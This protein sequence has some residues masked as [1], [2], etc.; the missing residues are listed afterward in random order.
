MDQ[1]TLP[2]TGELER[3]PEPYNPDE[4][5]RFIIARVTSRLGEGPRAASRLALERVW[6]RNILF[7]LGVQWLDWDSRARSYTPIKAPKWF[8]QPV[9]NEIYPRV[10]RLVAQFLKT[11]PVARVRPNTGEP[12]DREAAKTAEQLLGHIEDVV[13]EDQLRHRLALGLTLCGT[14]IS[15]E[16]FN[17]QTGPIVEVPETTTRMDPVMD[18]V[19]GCETPG[20]MQ[21]MGPEMEGQDCPSC[22]GPLAMQRFQR[23]SPSGSLEYQPVQDPVLDPETGEP[24]VHRFYQG[25]IQSEV[26]YPFAFFKDPNADTLE[27]AEW[28][29]DISYRPLEWIRRNF[30]DN[31]RFVAEESGVGVASF[32][33]SALLQVV[34]QSDPGSSSP[35]RMLTG[36]A[37]VLCYE[38]RPSADFPDGLAAIVAHG[39]LLWY[40]PLPIS[41]EFS[42][43]ACHYAQVPGRFEGTGPVEQMVPLNRRLNGI[44]AQ[45]IINNKTILNPWIMAPKGSG[46]KPGQ[47]ALRPAAVVEYNF[48]G[49]GGTAPQIVPGQPLPAQIMEVKRQILDALERIAGTQDVLRGDVPPGVKSG[50]ALN[51]LGEQSEMMHLPRA[52]RW[53]LFIAERGRKWLLLAKQHYRERRMVKVLGAGSTWLVR[54]LS[55]ADIRDNVDV[56]VEAGSSLPRSRTAQI[57]LLFDALQEGLLGNPAEDV[58]LRQKLL[59][60]VGLVGFDTEIGPDAKRA[61]MENSMLDAGEMPPVGEFEN[62]DVH[63]MIHMREMKDPRFDDKSP[64]AK[65]AF[66]LHVK[67]TRMKIIEEM[68]REQGAPPAPGGEDGGGGGGAASGDAPAAASP[69]AIPPEAPPAA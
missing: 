20:C 29:G 57:Q 11:R 43:A 8:P 41:G 62:S 48:I 52:R 15:K 63:Y 58:L 37:A 35:G 44:D 1:R 23:T 5:E 68:Q 17:A 59:D 69:N 6:Y 4:A 28:C 14:I 45:V 30:P 42:Y 9:T 32:Y 66:E 67:A 61:L 13:G 55:N 54:A 47:V 25:E 10:E 16:W 65:R 64:A 12:A 22:G 7:Y 46:L 33:Q 53:E 21:R 60:E 27:R 49:G 31:G 19:A 56:T 51:F 36:G 24:V 26:I 18:E 39:V 50:V 40:G 38:E 3:Q 34:G 2:A